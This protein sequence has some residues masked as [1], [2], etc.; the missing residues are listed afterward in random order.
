[1]EEQIE[2]HWLGEGVK[3]RR[4][5]R[6][7][8]TLRRRFSRGAQSLRN[9]PEPSSFSVQT[10]PCTPVPRYLRWIWWIF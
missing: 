2:T 10:T 8:R 5:L 9:P 1:M 6:P 3:L 7:T 4:Q